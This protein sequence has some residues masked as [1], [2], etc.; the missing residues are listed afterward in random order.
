M[1]QGNSASDVINAP[2]FD[3]SATPLER[4]Y[5]GCYLKVLDDFFTS[6]EC[7]A[8]IALAESDQEW[9]QAA[10]HYGL[11]AHENYINTEYRNSERILRFDHDVAEKLYQRLLPYIQELVEIK[12]GDKWEGIVARPGSVSGTWT[13]VGLNER[14]SFLR[15]GPGHYFKGH[16]DGQLELPDG[17]ISRVTVQIYLGD[18]GMEGGATRIMGSRRKGGAFVDIEPKKGRVLIFQQRGIFHSGEDVTK[19]VKYALRS[20]FMFRHTKD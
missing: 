5:G 9:K 15:Y 4:D 16:C 1:T 2:V 3:W 18:E 11:E 13:L 10:V 19:G 14:L 20:D 12:A 8:L 6:E 17:R 7:A